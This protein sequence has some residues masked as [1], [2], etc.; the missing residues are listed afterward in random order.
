MKI[1]WNVIGILAFILGALG[2]FLPILPTTPLWL[3]AA[4]CL[5]KG[6]RTLYE[7][8]MSIR[9]FNSIVTTYKV[10]RAIPLH[11]KIIAISTLWI[12]IIISCVIVCKWWITTLLLLIASGVT[13]HIL[14]Y[15]TLTGEEWERLKEEVEKRK[16]Q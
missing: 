13:W 5:L 1:L 11:A 6:S 2:L 14:S 4:Y 3:L 10:Y 9:L 16:N 12:T 7:R 8:A 15:R